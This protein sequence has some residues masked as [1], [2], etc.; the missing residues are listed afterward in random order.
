MYNLL[1]NIVDAEK[2]I[3]LIMP[4]NCEPKAVFDDTSDAEERVHDPCEPTR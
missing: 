3:F 4:V 2:A 1:C